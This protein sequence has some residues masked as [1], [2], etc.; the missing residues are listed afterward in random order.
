MMKKTIIA[1]LTLVTLCAAATANKSVEPAVSRVLITVGDDNI[2]TVY[3]LEGHADYTDGKG[4]LAGAIESGQSVYLTGDGRPPEPG[5]YDAGAVKA[6]QKDVEPTSGD[7]P[8][9][10]C[11]CIPLLTGILAFLGAALGSKL[12]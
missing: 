5:P 2:T 4:N 6:L 3:V 9:S 12:M 1:L 11:N 8:K 10:S 7:G